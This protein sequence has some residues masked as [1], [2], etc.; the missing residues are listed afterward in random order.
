MP[1]MDW[2]RF[3]DAHYRPHLVVATLEGQAAATP[4]DPVAQFERL[5]TALGVSG[6]YALKTDATS[7]R[8]AFEFDTDAE[9]FAAILEE[10]RSTRELEWASRTVGRIDGVA[11]K[12]IVAV[13]RKL[14]LRRPGRPVPGDG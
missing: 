6:N 9:R 4:G 7:L 13:L 12:R 8:A 3:Q 11:Q 5:A 2:D 1:R 10:G 14:R